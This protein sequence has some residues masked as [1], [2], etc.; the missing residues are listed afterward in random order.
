MSRQ[1][2]IRFDQDKKS[3]SVRQ[4][5]GID[6]NMMLLKNKNLKEISHYSDNFVF[7]FCFVFASGMLLTLERAEYSLAASYNVLGKNNLF[8]A[9]FELTNFRA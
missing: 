9:G 3:V 4:P 8:P 5:K 1:I 2:L 7:F 6:P